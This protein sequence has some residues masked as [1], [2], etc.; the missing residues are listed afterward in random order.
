ME[1]SEMIR[2]CE[3]LLHQSHRLREETADDKGDLG[4]DEDGFTLTDLF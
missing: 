4:E 1:D 3:E 2:R